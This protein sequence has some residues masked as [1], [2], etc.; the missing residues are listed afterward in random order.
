MFVNYEAA[1]HWKGAQNDQSGKI[2]REKSVKGE[3]TKHSILFLF[4][5]KASDELGFGRESISWWQVFEW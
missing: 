4:Y 1:F 5:P 3:I 2:Y